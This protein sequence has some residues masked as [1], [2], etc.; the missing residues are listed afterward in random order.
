[1]QSEMIGML[2]LLLTPEIKSLR[3]SLAKVY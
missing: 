1:M 2:Q 3:T